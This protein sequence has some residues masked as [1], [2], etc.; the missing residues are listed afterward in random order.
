MADHRAIDPA[1]PLRGQAALVTGGSTGIGAA[2]ATALAAAGGAV[3][4]NYYSDRAPAD[5]N[6]AENGRAACWG[7][8][9]I[10]AGVVSIKK[11]KNSKL[12]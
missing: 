8:A 1:A 6:V 11:K 2:C 7:K 4:G 10:S 9:E 12:T 5:E 3:V